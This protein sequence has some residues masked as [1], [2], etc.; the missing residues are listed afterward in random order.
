MMK[1]FE[2]SFAVDSAGPFHEYCSTLQPLQVAVYSL[3]RR[4]YKDGSNIIARVTEEEAGDESRQY[5][6]FKEESPDEA[7]IK[8]VEETPEIDVKADVMR[9]VPELMSTLDYE[10]AVDLVKKRTRYVYDGFHID[11]DEYTA[12]YSAVVIE[13]EGG[14]DY[15]NL[16]YQDMQRRLPEHIKKS[17]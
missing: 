6:D 11:V 3:R 1:E 8:H 16:A 5:V 4:V 17:E 10:L 15:A 7:L 12:P 13:V 14:V 2:Y 9:L